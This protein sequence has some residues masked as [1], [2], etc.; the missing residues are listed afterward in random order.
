MLVTSPPVET[1][2]WLANKGPIE[3]FARKRQAERRGHPQYD[4]IIP[5]AGLEQQYRRIAFNEPPGDDA[6]GGTRAD[7]DRVILTLFHA[8]YL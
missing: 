5:W 1:W 4:R 3:L 6:A 8:N 7:D 2:V